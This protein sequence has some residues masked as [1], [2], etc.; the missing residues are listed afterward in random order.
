MPRLLAGRGRLAA[1]AVLSFAAL[2]TVT[3]VTMT[4][5][6]SAQTAAEEGEIAASKPIVRVGNRTALVG[7]FD[8]ASDAPV[9]IQHRPRGAENWRDMARTRTG[10]AGR[11]RVVISPRQNGRWR[12]LLTN[13]PAETLEEEAT[14]EDAVRERTAREA[15]P[16]GVRVRSRTRARAVRRHVVAGQS[17]PVRGRV[18][19]DG[20]RKVIV[21]A[22]GRRVQTRT[23]PAGRY[24]VSL[25]VA[26]LGTHRV[27]VRAAANRRALASVAGAGRVTAYRP[28][29]ASWYG[30]GFYGRRTACGQTLTPSTM[31]TA[32]RTLPC[33]TQL[34]LR[35]RG[36]TV[37][38][39]VID[40][41]PFHAGRELDLTY[42]TKQRLG[43]GSTGTVLMSR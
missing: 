1:V 21:R 40:R 36:R 19:P 15:G 35:H 6:T 43:F 2:T 12:A 17:V 25:P 41:G 39:R 5:A 37:N 33:G 20:R 42:A 16:T 30:P 10:G 3:T 28:V 38:V 29:Q 8:D 23:G 31:G 7:S 13:P 4:P 24:R 32:H 34:R 22:A 18:R 27:R 14:D 9:Q 26:R 11:Y